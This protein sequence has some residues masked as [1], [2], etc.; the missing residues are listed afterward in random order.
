M[1][2]KVMNKA[3][4][5][6]N[7]GF[8][9]QD[10]EKVIRFGELMMEYSQELDMLGVWYIPYEEYFINKLT[11]NTVLTKLRTYEPWNAAIPWTRCLKNK[12]VLVVHPFVKTIQSQYEKRE[13]LFANTDMLPKF[14]LLTYKAVQTIAGNRDPRF[15]DWFEA[16]DFMFS[17]IMKM[18]FDVAILGCG[19]YG[20]PLAAKIKQA[21]KQ[22]VHIGG[23]TQLLFGIKG[24][25]WDH[26]PTISKLYNEYW[27]RPGEK[28]KPEGFHKIESG[29]YW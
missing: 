6:N 27:V 14:E 16:L 23:A 1:L 25:R 20:F 13:Q 17:D 2:N 28:E 12:K 3:D 7:A 11:K 24:S 8:F 15:D 10:R 5:F 26:H 21:G 22:A 19:A 18:D 9:P 4:I 29:C